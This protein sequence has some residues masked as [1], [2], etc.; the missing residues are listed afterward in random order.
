V[1]SRTGSLTA[2]AHHFAVARGRGYHPEQVDRFLEALCE[3]RD[4]AWERAARLT[5]LAN[6]MDAECAAVR[7]RLTALGP[8]RY[9]VLGAGAQQLLELAE[10]EAAAVRDRAA[11]A[12]RA[13]RGSADSAGEAMLRDARAA[14]QARIA[15]ADARAARHLESAGAQAAELRAEAERCAAHLRQEAERALDD[16]RQQVERVTSGRQQEQGERLD[17]QR[18]EFAHLAA[19][20]DARTADRFAAAE[21]MLREAEDAYAVV[22][23]EARRALDQAEAFAVDTLAEAGARE[24]RILREAE[25]ELRHHELRCEEIREHLALVSSSLS[26]LTA[27]PV[28]HDEVP[29]V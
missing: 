2:S 22:E 25:R 18:R 4:A 21:A 7:E 9:E 6:E 12:L 19:D 14:A 5:V 24:D 10:A 26:A 3:D 13:A 27:R 28:G 8:V 16:V 11:A 15:A 29:D 1:S 23:D 17:A 20:A